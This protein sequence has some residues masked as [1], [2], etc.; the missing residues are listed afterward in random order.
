MTNNFTTI[1]V[2]KQTHALL[3][4]LGKKNDS[5]DKIINKLLDTVKPNDK[6]IDQG[7]KS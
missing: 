5:M 2:N 1:R 3:C 6:H 7:Q 4:D